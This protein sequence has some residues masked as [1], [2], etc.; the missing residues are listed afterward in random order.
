VTSNGVSGVW[1]ND[2]QGVWHLNEATG[3]TNIDATNNTNDG[4]PSGD[5]AA[6]VGVIGG[7]LDFGVPGDYTRIAIPDDPTL[8]LASYPN[9]TMSGWARPTSYKGIKWPTIYDYQLTAI[10]LTV[11]EGKDPPPEGSIEHWRNDDTHVHGNTVANF[12]AWNYVVVVR[13]P[14]TTNMYLNGVADGSAASVAFIPL[15]GG[16]SIGA[17]V[18]YAKDSDFLG[19]L[20]EVRFSGTDRSSGWILTEYNNQFAPATFITTGPEVFAA[21]ATVNPDTTAASALPSNGTNYTVDFTVVN[22]GIQTDDF[23]LLTSQIPGSAISV[24]SITGTGV[25]QGAD[26]DSARVALVP[27]GDSVLVTVTYSLADVAGGTTDTLLF[28][29]RSVADPTVNADGRLEVTVIRPNLIT[30][31]AV[32]PS[33]TQ[34]PGIDLTYTVTLT[35]DGDEAATSVMIVDSLAGQVEFKVGTVV[36]NLP[37]GVG[38]VVE[39]SND[40]GGSWTYTPI[41]A[42]CSAPASYDGCVTHIRWRLQNDLGSVAPDNTGDVQ[43]VVRIK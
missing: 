32:N 12:D 34:A 22:D 29:A 36:N 19:L 8:D 14:T 4:T 2:Y 21:G 26:P 40:D 30:T 37:G 5:P 23:D 38:V 9:W 3:A 39:Y 6:S 27:A 41:S 25:T 33:G 18:A 28:T 16:A 11:K 43:F 42:G 15:G 35:N 17:D 1:D 20:D 13:T 7:A 31:K 24:V 10:G